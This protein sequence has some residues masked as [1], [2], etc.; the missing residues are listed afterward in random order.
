[1]V[2]RKKILL[3]FFKVANGM[4]ATAIMVFSI[5]GLMLV[6]GEGLLKSLNKGITREGVQSE[7]RPLVFIS[8]E[9]LLRIEP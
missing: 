2:D 9:K 7:C 8:N 1:M 4:G 6:G 3:S 5:V